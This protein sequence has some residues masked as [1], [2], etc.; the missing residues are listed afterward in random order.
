MDAA[1]G[2]KRLRQDRMTGWNYVPAPFSTT[3]NLTAINGQS[4]ALP[5]SRSNSF[6]MNFRTCTAPELASA[7]FCGAGDR[8]FLIVQ[9]TIFPASII[10]WIDS[11]QGCRERDGFPVGLPVEGR[12]RQADAVTVRAIQKKAFVGSLRLALSCLKEDG[13]A[14]QAVKAKPCGRLCRS[15]HL[16]P[17]R[18]TGLPRRL[19]PPF[20]WV[21]PLRHNRP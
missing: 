19:A 20:G 9:S 13:A 21:I 4:A 14:P 6:T 1:T 12:P 15:P 5:S 8:P 16:S 7:G 17:G 2:S 11:P 10:E 18:K 3:A